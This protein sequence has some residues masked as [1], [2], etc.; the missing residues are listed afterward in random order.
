M[1]G[2]MTPDEIR[3]D[4]AAR[5]S[6]FDGGANSYEGGDPN[7]YQGG[8]ENN[9]I[10]LNDDSVDFCGGNS[11]MT[12]GGSAIQ[13]SFTL[14]NATAANKVIALTPTFLGSASAIATNTGETCDYVLTDG[15]IDTNITGTAANSKLKIAYLQNFILRNPSRLIRMTVKSNSEDGFLGSEMVI[16]QADPYRSPSIN[17][18]PITKFVS[19][20]Q[21]N[22]KKAVIDFREAGYQD[23]QLDDQN[24]ILIRISGTNV[25]A[26]TGETLNVTLE[27]GAVNNPARSLS[28]KAKKAFRT[29]EKMAIAGLVKKPAPAGR[30]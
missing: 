16:G 14:T 8:D 25:V 6:H 20:D 23:M 9:Y 17:R 7:Q 26:T 24:I 30:R 21:Y 15:T 28:V 3:N 1:K 12:E 2:L 19:T 5:L 13:F 22:A 18:L 27:F 29:M 4:A 11:F 10:G